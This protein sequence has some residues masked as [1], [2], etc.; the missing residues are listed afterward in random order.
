MRIRIPYKGID[1]ASTKPLL[2][3]DDVLILDVRDRDA[4]RAGHI[5]EAHN[6]SYSL[7]SDVI[8]NAPRELPILVYCARGHASQE[9]AQALS[10]FGFL[11]VYNL[12]GGFD[13]WRA[14]NG[15]EA[16]VNL[17]KPAIAATIAT[18]A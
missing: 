5:G 7:L 4:Y 8:N 9:F 16:A 17:V 12:D 18:A 15:G 1:A 10:D 3:R 14:L 2:G 13:A 6:I 11:E